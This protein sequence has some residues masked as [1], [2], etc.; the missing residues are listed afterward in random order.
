MKTA[1]EIRE[2]TY[3]KKLREESHDDW[4]WY[5]CFGGRCDGV[6]TLEMIEANLAA[7]NKVKSGYTCTD[8]RGYH[9]KWILVKRPKQD[10]LHNVKGVARRR[11][12]VQ[13]EA[14]EGRYPPLP[15]PSCS[16][17]CFNVRFC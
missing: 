10:S 9:D 13:S 14:N 2:A 7:G 16:A 8:I 6:P 11:L 1:E 3:R 4:S 5:H 15:L 17:S 12:D